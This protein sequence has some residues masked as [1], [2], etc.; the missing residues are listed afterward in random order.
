MVGGGG[1][2]WLGKEPT[3]LCLSIASPPPSHVLTVAGGGEV[4]ALAVFLP[5][6]PSPFQA[7]Q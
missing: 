1:G 3:R 4:S 7:L 2:V 5:V 6:F